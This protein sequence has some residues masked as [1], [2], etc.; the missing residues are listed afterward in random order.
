MVASLQQLQGL[1]QQAASLGLG[2]VGGGVAVAHRE[3]AAAHRRGRRGNAASCWPQTERDR[4]IP[5]CREAAGRPAQAAGRLDLRDLPRSSRLARGLQRGRRGLPQE[6]RRGE[7]S[8][9]R[10]PPAERPVNVEDLQKKAEQTQ[11]PADFEAV[12][13][14]FLGAGQVNNAILQLQPRARDRR[15]PAPR[16]TRPSATPCCSTVTPTPPAPSTARRSKPT[17]PTTRRANLA[18]LHCRFF[19]V[20]GAKREVAVLKDVVTGPDVDP[21]WKSCK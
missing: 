19:D 8:P 9:L 4:R 20:E 16:S 14:A 12:A 10:G 7:A 5:R 2:G 13:Q 1:Y 6:G 17:P 11:N 15:G 3:L 18:A 21:E